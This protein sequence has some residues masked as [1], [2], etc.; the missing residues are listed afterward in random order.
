VETFFFLFAFDCVLCHPM[1]PPF[2]MEQPTAPLVFAWIPPKLTLISGSRAPPAST[3]PSQLRHLV[4]LHFF[5]PYAS[6]AQVW[7]F[8][9]FF[10]ENTS[11]N[12]AGTPIQI[13]HSPLLVRSFAMPPRG[14]VIAR[15]LLFVCSLASH[16]CRFIFPISPLNNH[17]SRNH[18]VPILPSP[19][20]ASVHCS[21]V[22]FLSNNLCVG[23][24][25]T[26]S[27]ARPS[28]TFEIISSSL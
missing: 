15:G 9:L 26:S 5:S 10:S 25:S 21:T 4:G 20:T 1:S 24:P 8:F 27:F 2:L 6:L 19:T 11:P 12:M 3:A 18:T 17:R 14:P 16:L 28:K 13:H 22:A 7:S 23:P